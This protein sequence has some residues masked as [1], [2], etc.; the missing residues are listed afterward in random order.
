MATPQRYNPIKLRGSGPTAS[1]IVLRD[2]ERFLIAEEPG[3]ASP[4]PQQK[5]A[6]DEKPEV[7]SEKPRPRPTYSI[8][9]PVNISHSFQSCAAALWSSAWGAILAGPTSPPRISRKP[10]GP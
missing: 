5:E 1:E 6:S 7:F 2:R 4:Q 3:E 10:C 9:I 8:E